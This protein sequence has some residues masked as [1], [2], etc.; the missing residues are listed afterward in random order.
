M[1]RLCGLLVALVAWAALGSSARAGSM[2]LALERMRVPAGNAAC[3]T[4]GEFCPDNEQFERVIAELAV[5]LAPPV[6]TGAA[7]LGPAGFYLGVGTALTPI[8]ADQH[9]WRNGTEGSGATQPNTSPNGSLMWNRLSARKG[10]PL[11]FEVGVSAGQ[12]VDTSMWVLAAELKW[13]LFEGF[14]SGAGQL[15]DVAVRGVLSSVVGARSLSL[16]THALDVTFS[17]PYVV[18]TRFRVVPFLALQG[19][20]VSAETGRV[21]LTPGDDAWA[22]CRPEAGSGPSADGEPVQ[23]AGDAADLANSQVF[24]PV[25]HAR[26]RLFAGAELMREYWSAGLSIG[27]DVTVPT[28]QAET[29]KDDLSGDLARQFTFQLSLGLRY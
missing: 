15:P 26:M 25:S 3:T 23:C 20:F 18:A 17:K 14:H 2:D 29:P 21:D 16:Q 1:G 10:L 12:G 27:Y 28:L 4:A 11:G 24:Q 6:T 13:A 9:P 22:A 5:T 19:V 7:T 8:S